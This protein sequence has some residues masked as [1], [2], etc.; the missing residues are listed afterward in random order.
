MVGNYFTEEAGG[1]VSVLREVAATHDVAPATVALGWLL[2]Q[3][4]VVAP[5]ASAR[6]AAQLADLTASATLTLSPDE[7]ATLDTASARTVALS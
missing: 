6:V 7:L 1:V 5:I 3:P 2:A 4:H